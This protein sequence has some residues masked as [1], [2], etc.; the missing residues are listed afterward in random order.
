MVPFAFKR[1]YF[2]S[3][4]FDTLNSAGCCVSHFLPSALHVLPQLSIDEIALRLTFSLLQTEGG[5]GNFLDRLVRE[6]GKRA[7]VSYF[8]RPPPPSPLRSSFRC[9]DA[10]V[11]IFL[12][13]RSSS[14][15]VF[16][17]RLPR[18]FSPLYI[19]FAFFYTFIFTTRSFSFSLLSS[20]FHPLPSLISLPAYFSRFPRSP[21]SS[22]SPSTT[23]VCLAASRPSVRP[24]PPLGS[25]LPSFPHLSSVQEHSEY[26]LF[27]WN[28]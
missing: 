7:P 23:V 19:S 16:V 8:P 27:V 14:V 25:L 12:F 17:S 26:R 3:I 15:L 24:S 5:K 13:R 28:D 20:L 22:S 4:P 10:S 2:N 21:L 1:C 18:P 6:R 11:V 9:T